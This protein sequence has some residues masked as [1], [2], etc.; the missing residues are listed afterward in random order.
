MATA[1]ALRT[2]EPAPS[3]AESFDRLVDA[4]QGLA[5]DQVGLIRL[6]IE[7]TLVRLSAGALLVLLG[8]LVM[9]S[10][11][12]AALCGLHIL[13]SQW[14]HP[15]ASLGLLATTTLAAGAV[16]A[17]IGSRRLLGS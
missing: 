14:M 1:R 7:A 15:A 4:A 2:S 9:I 6:E 12:V 3:V 13:L 17:W 10:G 8:L 11:W 5:T 16:V